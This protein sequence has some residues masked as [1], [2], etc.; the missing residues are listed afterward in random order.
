M[1]RQLNKHLRRIF[2]SGSQCA[3]FTRHDQWKIS[4]CNF[5]NWHLPYL[6]I[7]LQWE[8]IN[9]TTSSFLNML[10]LL[11]K[12]KLTFLHYKML[13]FSIGVFANPIFLE[14]DLEQY[15]LFIPTGIN[16]NI[17]SCHL[18]SA[19]ACTS[20]GLMNHTLIIIIPAHW[21]ISYLR[22]FSWPGYFLTAL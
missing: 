6:G 2:Y 10:N 18:R 12:M 4:M 5:L 3:G 21:Y 17:N 11:N 22:C 9:V 15:N 14:L 8:P 16:I 7:R 13:I 19:S 20:L 1:I